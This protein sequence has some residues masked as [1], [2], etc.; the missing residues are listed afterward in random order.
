VDTGC[1]G[2]A[3]TYGFKKGYDGY[4]LSMEIGKPLFEAMSDPNYLI[5]TESSVCK[6]QIEAGVNRNVIHP[7]TL[8]MKAYSG[9]T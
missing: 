6:M 5:V 8:L 2:M 4:D 7:L 1:C 9:D 3:G